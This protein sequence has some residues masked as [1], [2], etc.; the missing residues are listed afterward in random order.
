[1]SV[2]TTKY[3][4]QRSIERA[5]YFLSPFKKLLLTDVYSVFI[6]K[7]SSKR[8]GEK[9]PYVNI[10]HSAD[11]CQYMCIFNVNVDDAYFE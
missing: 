6:G 8:C 3:Y 2:S 1:M 7:A 4:E 9:F 5:T 11:Q 10:Q